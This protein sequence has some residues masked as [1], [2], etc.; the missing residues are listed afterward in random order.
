MFAG[1]FIRLMFG[2]LLFL[3]AAKKGYGK[4]FWGAIGI[5]LGP[6]ALVAIFLYR[7]NVDYSKAFLSGLTGALVG[8]GLSLCGWFLISWLPAD[9]LV[10]A[11]SI[12]RSTFWNLLLPGISLGLGMIFFCVSLFRT[13]HQNPSQ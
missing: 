2:L 12:E 9:E 13:S 5:I 3:I 8:A 10:T 4:F 7:P 6:I 1:F 11:Q